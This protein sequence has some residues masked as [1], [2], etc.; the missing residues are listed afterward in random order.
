MV[1]NSRV[2]DTVQNWYPATAGNG[3]KAFC[4]ATSSMQIV[5][6]IQRV[7]LG[8]S[9]AHRLA[10]ISLTGNDWLINQLIITPLWEYWRKACHSTAGHISQLTM[11]LMEIAMVRSLTIVI[12]L[13]DTWPYLLYKVGKCTEHVG[14]GYRYPRRRCLCAAWCGIC[15]QLR[16]VLSLR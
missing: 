9:I 13:C 16:F 4:G 7:L 10:H 2:N 8:S 12:A 5:S 6:T 15:L 14:P 11:S 1:K 3:P